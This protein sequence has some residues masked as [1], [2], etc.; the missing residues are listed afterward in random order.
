MSQT[1]PALTRFVARSRTVELDELES[2]AILR[3]ALGIRDERA[4]SREADARRRL[5]ML[6]L[7]NASNECLAR[8]RA[9]L[10]PNAHAVLSAIAELA[11]RKRG[12]TAR[13]A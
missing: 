2:R 7:L 12:E 9:A 3:R 10:G 13:A 4:V 1:H 11:A 8:Y 5:Q 6:A